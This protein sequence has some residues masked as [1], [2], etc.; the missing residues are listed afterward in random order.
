[1][2]LG[3]PHNF[4]TIVRVTLPFS[5][6]IP[7]VRHWK[8]RS[9]T[10]ETKILICIA[11]QLIVKVQTSTVTNTRLQVRCQGYYG[12][13]YQI[14]TAEWPYTQMENSKIIDRWPEYG[15]SHVRVH[16]LFDKYAPFSKDSRVN[17]G[18]R[19]E[20]K[21]DCRRRRCRCE[22]Q[23]MTMALIAMDAYLVSQ[24]AQVKTYRFI[25]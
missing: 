3:S 12:F 8:I 22:A 17:R 2:H 13:F 7:S 24:A 18:E 16:F 25:I 11:F 4:Q 5:S 20:G 23:H 15:S 21:A 9:T 1:M 6:S 14:C 19:E 10:R